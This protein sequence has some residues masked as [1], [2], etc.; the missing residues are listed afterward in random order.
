MIEKEN[1]HVPKVFSLEADLQ[2]LY[3]DTR[4]FTKNEA[5]RAIINKCIIIR[6]FSIIRDFL[7]CVITKQGEKFFLID[8]EKEEESA[9]EFF[10]ELRRIAVQIPN[11][12][13]IVMQEW[14]TNFLEV[15]RNLDNAACYIAYE[16]Y[17]FG[18]PADENSL[19]WV[20]KVLKGFIGSS[21]EKY[22][23]YDQIREELKIQKAEH[24]KR[25]FEKLGIKLHGDGTNKPFIVEKDFLR[26]KEFWKNRN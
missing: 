9:A 3:G 6:D 7:E 5:L 11:Y 13:I 22:V 17:R 26:L 1:N 4:T 20:K 19:Q 18:F 10:R 12:E 16:R 8:S 2:F 23:Y 24:F 21:T 15:L 25:H 14:K